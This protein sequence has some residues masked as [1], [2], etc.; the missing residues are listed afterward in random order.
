MIKYKKKLDMVSG[1]SPATVW[2]N[3]YD[4]DVILEF[5]LFATEGIFVVESGTIVSIRG[6]KPDGNGI[7]MTA[8]LNSITDPDTGVETFYATVNVDQQMTAVAGKSHY[9]LTLMKGSKELNTAN[10]IMA[11]ERAALD[12]DTVISGSVVRE[13]VDIMDNSDEIIAAAEAAVEARSAVEQAAQ[14]AEGSK[15][16]AQAAAQAASDAASAASSSAEETASTA[17]SAMYEINEK[18]RQIAAVTT[19]AQEIALQAMSKSTDAENEVAE[20]IASQTGLKERVMLL[21]NQLDEKVDGAYVQAGYLYLTS[22]NE[23]VAGPLGPF[24]GGGGGGG[25]GGNAAIITL[26]NSSGWVSKTV[27]KNEPCAAQITWRS[28]ENDLPTGN[29]SMTI[30]NNGSTKVVKEVAQG[31]VDIDLSPFINTGSNIVSIKVDDIYGNS[32]TVKLTVSVVEISLTS[33][34]DASVPYEGPINFGY[35]PTGA[36]QKTVHFIMDGTQ[37]GTS[38]TSVSG[39]QQSFVIP[40]QSHGAHNFE[41]Y[42]DCIINGQ[43]V[44]SNHLRYDLICLEVLNPTPIIASAY[45]GGDVG[46]YTMIQ[47]PYTVYDPTSMTAE[48]LLKVNGETVSSQTVDRTQQTWGYRADETGEMTLSITTGSVSKAFTINVTESEIHVEPETDSL[49]LDL[50]S[51]GRSNNEADPSIWTYEDIEASLTGFNFTSDGWKMDKD[52][53]TALRISGDARVA[54]PYQI[55]ETD[56]RSTGKTIEIEFATSSVLDYDAEII[57]CFSGGRGIKITPQRALLKSEQSEIGMQFKEDE[58][59]RI[60][61]VVEKRSENRLILCYVNGIVSGAVK[62]PTDDDFSQLEPV[63]ISIGSDYATTDIYH[64]RIYDNDLT[65]SQVLGNW[66]AD[67][68]KIDDMLDRYTRN[69]IYDDYGAIVISKLPADLPYLVITC[70]EL[71]QYKGDKKTVSGSYTD[72]SYPARSFTFEG[73]QLDVQGTSSQYYERK[74]YKLK[75][76]GGFDMTD[77]THASKYPLRPGQIPTNVFC[78]K[79]DVASSEGANNVELARAYENAC[80]YRTPAQTEDDRIR[81]AIDGFPIVIFWHDTV[82]DRTTFLGKY[83]FNHDKGAEEEFGFADDDESWEV[84]NNTSDRVLF[85]SDDYTST[86][87]DESGNVVPA[88]LNDF[89]ARY[90]DEDPAYID[91]THLEAFAQWIVK[92]DT[93]TATGD[94]LPAPVEYDGVT[95]TVDSAAY[96]LAKFKAELGNYV[97][98]DSAIFYYLFTELFLMVDSRA[99]NMFPSFMGAAI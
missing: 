92:T 47:I 93:E 33:S 53:A 22:G 24:S 60:T 80:P 45:Q 18:A 41:V 13:L 91:K 36:V 6:T 77:G 20:F 81:Q 85:K 57:S 1:T 89:E 59:V 71:P 5:E 70:P 86:I 67:S 66:I 64:I 94:A 3:Q 65:R 37:I 78:F 54:I 25:G 4:T 43:E 76:K 82:N 58:H 98:M 75:A 39:R 14:D 84:K 97:E 61:F 72:P 40:Q 2:L 96:R 16:A 48:V 19:N 79:A 99:K 88:W 11:V 90:P 28:T 35:V 46:Q 62:Y 38:T 69:N 21:Q 29:G 30:S 63:G 87:I 26:T 42:F 12:K 55:F 95:Y 8:E 49:T 27:A 34:F 68:T 10:F 74:N 7:S 9:E 23:V 44:E 83:N 73:G 31:I 52:G 50:S 32:R 56:A 15:T 51:Y 17:D